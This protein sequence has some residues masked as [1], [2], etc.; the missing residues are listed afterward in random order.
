VQP[1]PVHVFVQLPEHRRLQPPPLH[2]SVHVDDGAQ[3]C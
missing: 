1:F 2:E 3:I